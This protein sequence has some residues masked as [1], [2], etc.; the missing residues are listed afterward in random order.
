LLSDST[1]DIDRDIKKEIYQDR[2]RTPEYFYFSPETLEFIG[3]QL[4]GRQYVEIAPDEH[5]RRWSNVLN[6]SLGIEARKLR[7]F[8]ADGELVPTLEEENEQALQDVQQAW[9]EA[10]RAR[11]EA[12]LAE[13]HAKREAQRAK[14]ETQRAEQEAQRAEQEAQRAEHEAQRAGRLAAKLR[15]LGLD[16][17]QV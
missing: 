12:R 8:T 1:A 2:F 11:E 13:R 14:Q 10:E 7:Y 15:E 16:P 17:D 3:F 5:G 9:E 6:L 4:V